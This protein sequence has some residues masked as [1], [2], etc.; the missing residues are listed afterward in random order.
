LYIEVNQTEQNYIY[1]IVDLY[2]HDGRQPAIETINTIIK[3]DSNTI[4]QTIN[5][6][7]DNRNN[8]R[9]QRPTKV[10]VWHV[11]I[12]VVS[13]SSE[14]IALKRCPGRRGGLDHHAEAITSYT[15]YYIED[16][17]E[18]SQVS[19]DSQDSHDAQE[20]QDSQDSQDSQES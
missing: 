20:S 18:A 17:I 7:Y 15:I 19:Q 11:C 13:V 1:N 5:Y 12:S 10:L 9:E 16:D 4:A 14:T 8:Q 2:M 6:I 3:I